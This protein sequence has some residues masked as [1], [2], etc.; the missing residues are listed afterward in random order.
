M[1]S[2]SHNA[3]RTAQGMR[4]FTLLEVLVALAVLALALSAGIKGAGSNVE[5]TAYLRDRTLAHWVAMNKMTE[6]DV[7]QKY[8]APD[9]TERGT[10]VL[11]GHEWHWN[12]R[13]TLEKIV[14]PYEF[15]V[16]TIE[17][18]RA[19]KDEQALSTLIAAYNVK[20]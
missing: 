9:N 5:N 2:V 17:V 13:T 8:P 14:E 10:S 7:F 3:V 1:R 6:L 4:G 16:A 15:G 20:R 19:E 11:A 18:R 12:V